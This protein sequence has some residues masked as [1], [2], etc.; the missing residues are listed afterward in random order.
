MEQINVYEAI[1]AMRKLSADNFPFTFSFISCDTSRRTSSGLVTVEN[2][3]LSKG[4]PKSKSKHA[5]NL[6]AY[7]NTDTGEKKHFWL[8]LLMSFNNI[9]I[10]HDR[11]F[12]G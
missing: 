10:S 3:V 11:V 4:L 8:P 6:I 9:K 5:N 12:R 1:R 2:A 7:E